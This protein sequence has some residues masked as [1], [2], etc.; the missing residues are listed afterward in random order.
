MQQQNWRRK[1]KNKNKKDNLGIST[2]GYLESAT[3][4]IENLRVNT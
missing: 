3:N 2:L 1:I 4:G